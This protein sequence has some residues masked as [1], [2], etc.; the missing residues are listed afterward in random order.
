MSIAIEYRYS[1]GRPERVAEIAAEFVQQEVIFERSG[2]AALSDVRL[3]PLHR[4][5]PSRAIQRNY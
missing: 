4:S 1:E 2:T 3:I 5:S